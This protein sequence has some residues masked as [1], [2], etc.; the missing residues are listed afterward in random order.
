[1]LPGARGAEVDALEDGRERDQ[2]DRLVDRH[3]KMP[4][5]VL[6]QGHPFVVV[7]PRARTATSVAAVVHRLTARCPAGRRRSGQSPGAPS[8]L[9][10]CLARSFVPSPVGPTPPAPQT[11]VYRT[12]S[13]PVYRGRN[14]AGSSDRSAVESIATIEIELMT[15][16][17]QLDTLGRKELAVR[18]RGPGRLPGLRT[19]ERLGPVPTPGR[20]TNC[21]STPP[22]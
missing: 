7:R 13:F 16:V 9:V 15:L 6:E 4:R 1:V 22:P 18:R 8:S 14:D 20:P 11:N 17:R 3:I 19:L 5:V 12:V 10:A 21:T 2:Q